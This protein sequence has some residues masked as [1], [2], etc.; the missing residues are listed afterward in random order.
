MLF[1]YMLE[2]R[3]AIITEPAYKE[4]VKKRL[5]EFMA[6]KAKKMSVVD[7]AAD[8]IITDVEESE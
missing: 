5:Y 2:V 6:E 3:L 7:A 8:V 1:T 4:Q